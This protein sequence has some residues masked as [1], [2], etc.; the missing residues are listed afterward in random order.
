MIH[1]G[2]Q[3]PPH[4]HSVYAIIIS[5]DCDCLGLEQGDIIIVLVFI[6]TKCRNRRRL[7]S[8]CFLLNS[9]FH[10]KRDGRTLFPLNLILFI[11]NPHEFPMRIIPVPWPEECE[12]LCH[13]TNTSRG[14]SHLSC[15]A[16]LDISN[17]LKKLVS[18]A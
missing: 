7:I 18:L 13:S 16:A 17:C 1:I 12:F 9:H 14:S 3:E 4:K 15:R 10:M 11:F 8:L 6:K 2:N 5:S